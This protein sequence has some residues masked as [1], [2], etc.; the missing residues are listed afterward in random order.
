MMLLF[1]VVIVLFIALY[2]A[3]NGVKGVLGVPSVRLDLAH[4]LSD[5]RSRCARPTLLR[6]I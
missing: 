1:A 4:G 2:F 5:G 6:T 3:V